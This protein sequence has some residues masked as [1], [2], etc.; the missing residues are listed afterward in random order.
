MSRRGEKEEEGKEEATNCELS[1]RKWVPNCVE[2][3]GDEAE[4]AQDP[5]ALAKGVGNG[6]DGRA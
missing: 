2:A 1:R 6:E 5:T 4:G 3:T